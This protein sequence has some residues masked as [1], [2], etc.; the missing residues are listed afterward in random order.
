[1]ENVRACLHREPTEKEWALI[2]DLWEA[3]LYSRLVNNPIWAWEE[4]N[5]KLEKAGIFPTL[6]GYRVRL[7][8]PES[9]VAP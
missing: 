7:T 6:N 1:M 9:A 4:F 5:E 2:D 3:Y 8:T